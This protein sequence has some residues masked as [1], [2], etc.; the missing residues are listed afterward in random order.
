MS[1]VLFILLQA[2]GA[3]II[4]TG[5]RLEEAHDACVRGECTVIRD[6][7]AS[8][9]LAEARFRD[10]KYLQAKNLLG[11]AIRRNRAKAASDPKPVAA[12]YEAYATV[13]LH[14]GSQD[15][16]RSA[17]YSQVRILRDNLPP[18]DPAVQTAA[19]AIG[20]MWL[21]IND[22]REAIRA[23]EL[24]ERQ[25][26]RNGQDAAAMLAGMR[27][28]TL[29]NALNRASEAIAVLD[30]LDKRPIA[31]TEGYR[32]ALQIIR[33]RLSARDADGEELAKLIRALPT[34]QGEAPLLIKSPRYDPITPVTAQRAAALAQAE[35][36][37]GPHNGCR[38]MGVDAVRWADVGFWIRPDG[39][40]ADAEILRASKGAVWTDVIL[41]Q[42]AGRQYSA[43][44]GEK[45]SPGFYKIERL[46]QRSAYVTPECSMI[47]RR[48]ATDGFETLDLTEEG[49]AAAPATN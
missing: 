5:K 2:S 48:V 38:T 15:D 41:K 20:D 19:T 21:K 23:Y 31:Q 26:L 45:D 37:G 3:D 13:S 1:L 49:S 44:S 43:S 6:A 27:R 46:T 25:A 12:L 42:I 8:I 33:L 17:V 47:A 11:R 34:R 30:E 9:A 16:Y 28:V 40:T 39:R 7:Q 18:D 22:P 35:G 14:E 10:G 24:T 32:S 29:M 4:V 36:M